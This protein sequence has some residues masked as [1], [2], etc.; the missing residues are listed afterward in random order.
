MML[1]CFQAVFKKQI[2]DLQAQ[3]QAMKTKRQQGHISL[4]KLVKLKQLGS[5]LLG[6]CLNGENKQK[7]TAAIWIF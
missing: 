7:L 5:P 4:L 2:E 3:F 1:S 6:V